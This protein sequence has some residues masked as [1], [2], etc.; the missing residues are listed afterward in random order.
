MADA[1]SRETRIARTALLDAM[2]ALRP[3]LRSVILVG[4]QAVYLRTGSADVALAEY[5]TDADLAIDTRTIGSDP[6]IGSVMTNAGFVRDPRNSNPGAWLS[7][8]GIPVDLMVPARIAGPGRRGV[9]APPHERSAMRR[10]VGLEA[11]LLDNSTLTVAGLESGDDRRL[12][13]RVAGSAALLV[14]KLHKLEERRDNPR[15][16]DDKDA[17]DVYRILV[18]TA[19]EELAANFRA[20]LASGVSGQVTAAA[21][22][23]LAELFAS[24]S[25]AMG[26]TMAGR[27]EAGI[28]DPAQTALAASLLAAD[29][30]SM[31]TGRDL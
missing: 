13:V 4:A 23:A 17:H 18:A 2:E 26:A 21:L 11:A 5:T 3:H 1:M 10:T 29:L 25:D 16:R 24:G 6:L 31:L 15:R 12:D 7:P 9:T 20:L 30:T 14:A 19:T 27:A 28:G 22:D 8:R